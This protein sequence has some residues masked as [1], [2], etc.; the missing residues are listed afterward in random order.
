M[1]NDPVL[2]DKVIRELEKIDK[3]SLLEAKNEVDKEYKV[4]EENLEDKNYMENIAGNYV[5]RI[6]IERNM[7]QT[8][9]LRRMKE[10]KLAK[11]KTLVIQKLNNWINNIDDS[12]YVWA[13][14]IEIALDLPDYV[15]VKMKGNPSEKEWE[16][17][18][19]IGK[20]VL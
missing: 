2:I 12:K 15:L 10:L 4:L 9:L 3:K 7:T 13:R 11:E 8:D 17:I 1:V 19:E 14:R 18:K 6:L 5:R 16:R 20:N